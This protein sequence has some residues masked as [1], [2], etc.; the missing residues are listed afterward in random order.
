M[1]IMDILQECE[2]WSI[3]I[4]VNKYEYLNYKEQNMKYYF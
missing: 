1:R 3:P 4:W 2:R